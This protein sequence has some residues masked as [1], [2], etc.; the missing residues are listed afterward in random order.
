MYFCISSSSEYEEDFEADDDSPLD[1][2][3]KEKKSPSSFSENQDQVKERDAF[4]TED[5]ERDGR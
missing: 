1:A 2:A 3:V 4:E 5:E